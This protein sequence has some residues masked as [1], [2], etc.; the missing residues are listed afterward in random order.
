MKI[1]II[2]K[3]IIVK[4]VPE[5]GAPRLGE[6]PFPRCAGG[7]KGNGAAGGGEGVPARGGG[8]G[9]ETKP[10]RQR[11]GRE[12]R[13]VWLPASPER[14]SREP[15]L[16][17]GGGAAPLS[18]KGGTPPQAGTRALQAGSLPSGGLSSALRPVPP[19]R[20]PPARPPPQGA[21]PL[22]SGRLPPTAATAPR[23]GRSLLRER[24]QPRGGVGT[25]RQRLGLGSRGRERG[26][27]RDVGD[28][29]GRKQPAP[30]RALADVRFV[31]WILPAASPRHASPAHLAEE[32][33][34]AA[35]SALPDL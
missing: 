23:N 27:P 32:T 13:F 24:E 14:G 9:G 31:G 12:R 7:T 17:K 8:N 15:P 35:P 30:A 21:S 10:R 33:W 18:L 26:W 16:E 29:T 4:G 20:P 2:K 34:K 28:L 25:R 22:A 1:I 5:A 19:L 6:R 11:E 3:K